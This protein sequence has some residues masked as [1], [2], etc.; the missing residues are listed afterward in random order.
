M[1]SLGAFAQ[2]TIS[3][4]T[5]TYDSISTRRAIFD[6]PASLQGEN[7]ER[8][9][10]YYNLKCSPLTP[11][12]SYNC[13]EWDYLTN[14]TIY[15]H[16]GDLDSNKVEG[17]QY[18][19]NNEYIENIKYSNTPYYHYFENYHYFLNYSSQVDNDFAVGAGTDLS[20][21]P[22]GASNETQHT[23]ILWTA[24]EISGAG[25]TAGDIDKLRFDITTN[26]SEM[27]HLVIKMK[28]SSNTE[29]TGFDLDTWTTVYDFNTNFMATGL[30]TLNLTYPFNYNGTDGI[31]LDIS[32]E[33]NVA[34]SDNVVNATNTSNIAP[35]LTASFKPSVV[36]L[37]IASNI[38]VPIF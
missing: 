29:L 5:F 25:V 13:G 4:Q 26:G 33:N 27:G 1:G 14:T 28:H 15:D 34:G 31:I 6:F 11:W 32:Y 3:V 23:Q 30:Q 35:T 22:F 18:L 20:T 37:D 10:L 16:T 17:P 7:F 24:A 12:D 38:L 36:P 19:V 21:A 8:V 2:D 9:L